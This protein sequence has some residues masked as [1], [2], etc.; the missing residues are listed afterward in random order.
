MARLWVIAAASANVAACVSVARGRGR[1]HGTGPRVGVLA[2]LKGTD[3]EPSVST[4]Y[5]EQFEIIN[6]ILRAE[7][8]AEHVEPLEPEE[9]FSC[10]M[11]GYSGLHYLR[12]VAAHLALGRRVPPPGD[13]DAAKD[14]ILYQEYWRRYEAGERLT[15]EHLIVHSDAEGFYVPVDFERPRDLSSL[16]LAGDIVGSVQRLQAECTDLAGALDMPTAMNHEAEELWEAIET[17]GL[18]ELRWQQ[19]GVE[20][21]S[22]LRLLAACG[23]SLRTGAAIVFV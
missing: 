5:G 13:G 21:F 3:A 1:R 6:K 17:Q 15:Y 12:R 20:T 2:E 11:Y 23:V 10:Q 19:Y 16:K 8:L 22:C 14:P 7:G 18:G 4:Y 9:T